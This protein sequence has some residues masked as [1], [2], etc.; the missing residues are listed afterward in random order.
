MEDL[1]LLTC[2]LVIWKVPFSI[3]LIRSSFP[4]ILWPS[5]SHWMLGVGF[6]MMWQW[7]WAVEPGAK[8]WLAGPWRMMGGTRSEGAWGT[9]NTHLTILNAEF[10]YKATIVYHLNRSLTNTA[11]EINHKVFLKPEAQHKAPHWSKKQ[12]EHFNHKISNRPLKVKWGG[13]L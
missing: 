5:F 2:K 7:S 1:Y 8:V 9:D 3:R 6:P 11:F 13:A 10:T 12:M 4:R